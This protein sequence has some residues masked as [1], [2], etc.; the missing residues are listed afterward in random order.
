MSKK[1]IALGGVPGTGKTTLV[2]KLIDRLG[3]D[4]FKRSNPC[5]QVHT[6]LNESDSIEIIGK[7]DEGELFAGT[8]RLS[9][10]VQPHAT[11]YI[12]EYVG[13]RIFIFEGDRL[14]NNSFLTSICEMEGVDLEI[15]YLTAPEKLLSER[16]KERGSDQSEKF[17]KGRYTKCEKIVS[18]FEF[19]PHISIFE[20]VNERD[21]NNILNEIM[22]MIKGE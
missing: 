6:E 17:I 14:F 18:S 2:R 19:M 8:D 21:Q 11:A 7:Y 12:K 4:K 16:Y 9:M 20:S 10:S 5:T 22:K 1:V 15:I 13:D 3:F